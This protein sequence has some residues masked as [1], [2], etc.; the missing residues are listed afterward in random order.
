[1]EVDYLIVGSGASAMAFLD[2]MLRETDATFAVVDRRDAPGGHWNDAYPFVRL[3]Q[4]SMYYGVA[5]RP[6]GRD[7]INPD[8]LNKGL[9]ELASGTEVTAYFHDLMEADFLPTGRVTYLPMSEYTDAA[10]VVSLLSSA[11]TPIN[12]RRK[13][14]DG[15][16]M[17]TQIPLTH[18]RRFQVSGEVTCI[19]PNDLPLCASGHRGFT[20]L[21]SGKTAIDTVLWLLER[22]ADPRQI[23]WVRPRDAWLINRR[24][25]Q[26]GIAFFDDTVGGYLRMLE[27]LAKA[28]TFQQICD[29][30][31]TAGQWMRIDPDVRPTM[32]HA[33]TVSEAE[34]A[35]LREIRDVIRA[36]HVRQ[37]EPERLVLQDTA[38]ET[39]PDRLYIDCTASAAADNI[40]DRDPVFSP[41]RI[42]LQM[43]RPYQPT[44][45]AALIAYLEAAV[46]DEDTLRLATR[47]TPMTDTVENWVERRLTGILNQGVWNEIDGLPQWIGAC[48]L[49]AFA[50]ALSALHQD[51]IEKTAVLARMGEITPAAIENM[52]RLLGSEAAEPT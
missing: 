46:V 10:K 23:T 20:V 6:L 35:R 5:S 16:R 36:G 51:D 25:V 8:G 26:P 14:V 44:F 15:R 18:K 7:R 3:H 47:P 30:M 28:E 11:E 31:E 43:I 45:S 52:R 29:G 17:R 9:Y 41:G 40:Q 32:F 24:K 49:D 39:D 27:I 22:G 19:P 50:S 2:V 12:I 13:L 4:P 42:N 21:G 48:R 34:L 37:I 33:A 38:L 1:M